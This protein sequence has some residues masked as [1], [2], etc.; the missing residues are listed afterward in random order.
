MTTCQPGTLGPSCRSEPEL[1]G[2]PV[3]AHKDESFEDLPE[4]AR[5]DEEDAPFQWTR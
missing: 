2:K 1:V 3:W 5:V 4:S